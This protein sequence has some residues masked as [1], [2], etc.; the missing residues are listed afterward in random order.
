MSVQGLRFDLQFIMLQLATPAN[1]NSRHATVCSAAVFLD[2]RSNV[3]D[4][5]DADDDV[6]ERSCERNCMQVHV[7][8]L[9]YILMCKV[10]IK[11]IRVC[12]CCGHL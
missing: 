9:T 6:S 11:C 12:A 10:M 2:I 4:L 3:T 8:R 7:M 1:Q 5:H